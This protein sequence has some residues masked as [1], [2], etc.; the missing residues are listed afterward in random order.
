[1]FV[2]ALVT[3][4]GRFLSRR[5]RGRVARCHATVIRSAPIP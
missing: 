4:D 2:N 5:S 3:P 1:M